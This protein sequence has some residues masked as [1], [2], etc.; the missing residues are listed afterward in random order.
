M[1]GNNKLAK[2]F[3]VTSI[4]VAIIDTRDML[5]NVKQIIFIAVTN[6]GN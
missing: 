1:L 6:K 5:K 2:I 3:V 4:D